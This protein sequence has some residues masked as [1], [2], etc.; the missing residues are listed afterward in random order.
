M[1]GNE[2]N[3]NKT[4]KKQKQEL[5]EVYQKLRKRNSEL[6]QEKTNPKPKQTKRKNILKHLMSIF[7]SVFETKQYSFISQKGSQT[8]SERVSTRYIERKISS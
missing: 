8:S 3:E 5:I 7:R 2:Y 1:L 6:R 4:L